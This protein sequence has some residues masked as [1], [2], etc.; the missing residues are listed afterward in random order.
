[1]DHP[2][3]VRAVAAPGGGVRPGRRPRDA[4]H[5]RPGGVAGAAPVRR[6]AADRR[7]R[8]GQ[9]EH[10]HAPQQAPGTLPERV[11]GRVRAVRPGAERRRG[12]AAVRAR[13]AATVAASRTS[14]LSYKRP[15]L[16]LLGC[17]EMLLNAIHSLL[18]RA[19][20]SSRPS[21]NTRPRKARL[22]AR[23]SVERLEAREVPA[24]I[25]V[26]NANDSG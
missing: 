12:R 26:T 15:L 20:R 4:L 6:A 16:L 10:R 5:R 23:P 18:P 1:G 21:S 24:T 17:A 8:A 11:H 3:P 14:R 19:G 22:R 25:L 13:P 9:L 7:R 2:G